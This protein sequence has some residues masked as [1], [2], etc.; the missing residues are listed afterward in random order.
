M[1]Y[2]HAYSACFGCGQVFAYNPKCVPSI[3]DPKTNEREP[4]CPNC[5]TRANIARARNGLDP[6]VP[7]P[8]AYRPIDEYEL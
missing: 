1:G 4:V 3:R 8:D 7:H 5:V 2:A 6:I